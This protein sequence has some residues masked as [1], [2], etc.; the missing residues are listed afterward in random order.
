[1][2][3]A[4]QIRPPMENKCEIVVLW[5]ISQNERSPPASNVYVML[6]LKCADSQN[7]PSCMWQEHTKARLPGKPQA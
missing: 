3:T 5:N 7:G 4:W 1:L 2:T 6:V